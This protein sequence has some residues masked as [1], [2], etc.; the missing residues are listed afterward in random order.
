MSVDYS[1]LM[2][3]LG[4]INKRFN[5]LEAVECLTPADLTLIEA[6]ILALDALVGIA[7][8]ALSPPGCT[9]S[10][11]SLSGIANATPTKVTGMAALTDSDRGGLFD[12]TGRF[13]AVTAGIYLIGFRTLWD[14]GGGTFRSSWVRI[15]GATDVMRDYRPASAS[16]APT[17]I[18]SVRYVLNAGEYAELWI[19]QDSGGL[20]I[21]NANM[22]WIE[23][24]GTRP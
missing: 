2:Q 16:F 20:A 5:K 12:G 18:G 10:R 15:N 19:E 11:G 13:T 21:A 6:Q 22:F 24:L 7:L 4:N 17:S 14:T 8:E 3:M 9:V 23:Y 1:E